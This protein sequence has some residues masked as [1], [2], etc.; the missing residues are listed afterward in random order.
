MERGDGDSRRG[1]NYEEVQVLVGY[2][3]Y[4]MKES[5]LYFITKTCL[6]KYTENFTTTK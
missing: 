2:L 5:N 3:N 4:Q 1:N 6:F